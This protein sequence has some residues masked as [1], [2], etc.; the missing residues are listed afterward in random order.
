L[1]SPSTLSE[2]FD[3]L[4]ISTATITDEALS[5]TWADLLSDEGLGTSV[6]SI[7]NNTY[8]DSGLLETTYTDVYNSEEVLTT[9][10]YD[11]VGHIISITQEG[12]SSGEERSSTWSYDTD[13][14]FISSETNAEG[15]I[16]NY[17]SHDEY[18]HPTYITL[19]DESGGSSLT[20]RYS[21]DDLGREIYH[22][23]NYQA[24]IIASYGLCSDGSYGCTATGLDEEFYSYVKTTSSDGSEKYEYYD[25]RGLLIKTATLL[26]DGYYSV[27]ATDY[28]E[29]QRKMYDT[30]PVKVSSYTSSTV[31]D[32]QEYEHDVLDHL[33]RK[34]NGIG[35]ETEYEWDYQ[36]SGV[37]VRT[38]SVKV[39]DS[40]TRETVETFNAL[41]Q[42]VEVEAPNGSIIQYLHDVRGNLVRQWYSKASYSS[43]DPEANT[44]DSDMHVLEKEYDDFGRLISETDPN[45]GTIEYTYNAF[46]EITEK[47]TPRV[48]SGDVDQAQYFSY[49]S[50]GR[51]TE[52]STADGTSCYYYD[53]SDYG[54]SVSQLTE[55]LYYQTDE[56]VDCSAKDTGEYHQQLYYYNYY[57]LVAY[58]YEYTEGSSGYYTR[59]DYNSEGQIETKYWGSET[60]AFYNDNYF[61]TEYSYE[62]GALNSITSEDGDTTYWQLTSSDALGNATVATLGGTVQLVRDYE[63]ATGQLLSVYASQNGV[64]ALVD[65]TYTYNDNGF[66]TEMVDNAVSGSDSWLGYSESY[67]YDDEAQRQITSVDYTVGSVTENDY[68]SYEYDALG[69]VR[70]KNG[71]SFSYDE[72]YPHRL[73]EA[74]D[75]DY[76]YNADGNVTSDDRRSYTYGHNHLPTKLTQDSN[77]TQYT[78]AA[79]ESLL[80]RMD[81]ESFSTTM[82]S[83]YF[84]GMQLTRADGDS[85]GEKTFYIAEGVEVTVPEDDSTDVSLQMSITNQVGSIILIAKEDGSIKQRLT[86]DPFGLI[87]LAEDYSSD[88][89][90]RLLWSGY[91][92]KDGFTGHEHMYDLELIHMKGRVYDPTVGRFLQVDNQVQSTN[93][94]LSYNRYAYVWNNPLALVDPS[95]YRV[96]PYS[97]Y[98]LDLN[99][100]RAIKEKIESIREKS[101]S[102]NSKSTESQA[103]SNTDSTSKVTDD[104]LAKETVDSSEAKVTKESNSLSSP[105]SSDAV[106]SS[107]F[108][109][110]RTCSVCSKI[111]GGTDYAVPVGTSVVAT[112]DGEVARANKSSSFG[113]I[114]IIDHGAAATGTG[115]V[116]TLYAHGSELKV[117]KNQKVTKG[118]EV[119]KSGNTGNSTGP[120]VHYEVIQTDKKSDQSD[121]YGNLNERHGPDG[122]EDLL[123]SEDN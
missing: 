76:S 103:T 47:S 24:T 25:T 70:E 91:A 58:Q 64:D 59:Y 104:S 77:T 45:S 39:D 71:E 96:N 119:M 48:L 40:F 22:E 11:S 115:N 83:W 51:M 120:H 114:V 108:S 57:G 13:T 56:S 74:L 30:L 113:N 98:G 38:V 15:H 123:E 50:L 117:K 122:L 90:S 54:Y 46:G 31:G 95:G 69:N 110:N 17:Y 20:T 6:T 9:Y 62:Y 97:F 67:Y 63:E 7:V 101:K 92:S 86:Y 12:R 28:D 14:G 16:T 66:L 42:I 18:G 36:G 41:D 105:V 34:T 23:I 79:D 75:G 4:L 100:I 8:Y 78:Y 49:D 2:N 107:L 55:V 29:H 88:D 10:G 44:G 27:V 5:D 65:Q 111:H 102:G 94:V 109:A 73:S 60:Y 43:S 89:A 52:Q 21:Y 72:D 85:T 87:T 35:G 33:V 37:N 84:N 118:Q 93:L 68:Y 81:T 112:A 61:T 26:P 82:E 106:V 121:F 99:P 19:T 32:A 116:Y 3:T 1:D 53:D 80:Y